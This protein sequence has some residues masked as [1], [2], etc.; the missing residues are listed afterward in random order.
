M[1][2]NRRARHQK[3]VA[4]KRSN[5]KIGLMDEPFIGMLLLKPA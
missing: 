5:T 3:P 4:K 2:P 1:E